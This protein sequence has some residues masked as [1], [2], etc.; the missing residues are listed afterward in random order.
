MEARIDIPSLVNPQYNETTKPAKTEKVA[1]PERIKQKR[2]VKRTRLYPGANNAP[3]YTASSGTVEKPTLDE[4]PPL[5]KQK[6]FP[7]ALKK[8]IDNQESHYAL[9]NENI[10]QLIKDSNQTAATQM[11]AFRKKDRETAAAGKQ[12]DIWDGYG[13]YI[14]SAQVALSLTTGFALLTAGSPLAV[15]AGLA[16]LFSGGASL[17]GAVVSQ[18]DY[19]CP[20]SDA[21]RDLGGSV[22]LMGSM[23]AITLT[24]GSRPG[25]E[26]MGV[27]FFAV[28]RAST[29]AMGSLY[30][31]QRAER[32]QDATGLRSQLNSG[33][34]IRFDHTH[35]LDLLHKANGHNISQ[36]VGAIKEEED[37]LRN[38]NRIY[39]G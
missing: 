22:A 19:K 1:I 23:A 12:K 31:R 5:K 37:A 10:S 26:K 9:E 25:L 6:T 34:Q 11:L 13:S 17:A 18:T 16:L 2:Q 27:A 24:T 7:E 39:R 4:T 36:I 20:L 33:R 15:G 3:S 29:G 32:E 28:A 38:T 21:A 14:F 30:E 8:F 35:E